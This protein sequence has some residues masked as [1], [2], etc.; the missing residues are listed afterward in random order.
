LAT[1]VLFD[2]AEDC[3]PKAVGIE[4]LE[5]KSLYKADPRY[6]PRKHGVKRRVMASREVIVAA[7]AFNTPQLLKLSGIGPKSELQKFHIPLVVDLPGVGTNLKDNYEVSVV[8]QSPENFSVFA[9]CT[10]GTAGDP[11]LA[12][13]LKGRGPYASDGLAC[14]VLKRSSVEGGDEDLV[15]FGGPV[16]FTGFFP[17]YSKTF[18]PLSSFTWDILKVH[19]RN[20]AGTVKL[21]SADPRDTPDI[22]FDFF[23]RGTTKDDDP[24]HDLEAM[25]EGIELARRIFSDV[26]KPIGPFVEQDPGANVSSP[27]QITEAIKSEA[28]SH[29]ATSTCAIGAEDDPMACLD[30]CF[31]VRRAD[32][33]RV[34]DASALPR[35]PGSFPSLPIYMISEKRRT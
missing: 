28:F 34:V 29:H 30:S 18:G 3:K 15:L 7:S 9:K 17:G 13:W 35:V 24:E 10:F 27:H 22:N 21:N 16:A 23:N 33:L 32:C 14:G 31:R 26:P 19:P 12:E 8:S 5:G 4:F 11:C 20:A 25:T 6:D 1:R 2:E